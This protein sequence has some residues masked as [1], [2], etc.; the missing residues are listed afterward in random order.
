MA[1]GIVILLAAV[2]IGSAILVFSL[3]LFNIVI[4]KPLKYISVQSPVVIQMMKFIFCVMLTTAL[5]NLVVHNQL[6]DLDPVVLGPVAFGYLLFVFVGLG[7]RSAGK[8]LQR[9]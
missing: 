9:Q 3:F 2:L 7:L 4:E 8:I 5:F 1:D 6:S